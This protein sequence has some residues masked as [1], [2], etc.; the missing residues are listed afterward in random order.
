MQAG[1]GGQGESRREQQLLALGVAAAV[2]G[3][4]LLIVL[5]PDA[6]DDPARA[7]LFISWGLA[8]LVAVGLATWLAVR[9]AVE[10]EDSEAAERI[11][12]LAERRGLVKVVGVRERDVER[13]ESLRATPRSQQAKGHQLAWVD[14]RKAALQ[15]RDLANADL[16]GADLRDADLRSCS[17]RGADLRGTDLRGTDLRGCDLTRADL[18]GARHDAGTLWPSPADGGEPG[19]HLEPQGPE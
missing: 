12:S 8:G 14:L 2:V 13:N 18:E 16:R 7:R 5:G 3:C 15:G 10:T 19:V 11:A 4:G 17:L 9:V 6:F 1:G